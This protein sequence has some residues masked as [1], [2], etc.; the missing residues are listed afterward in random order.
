MKDARYLQC[1]DYF[2]LLWLLC[3]T[4]LSRVLTQTNR[5]GQNYLAFSWLWCL[6]RVVILSPLPT[7]PSGVSS[8]SSIGAREPWRGNLGMF[9]SDQRWVDQSSSEE[10]SINY[11]WTIDSKKDTYF[12]LKM[13]TLSS[14]YL[15]LALKFHSI[16]LRQLKSEKMGKIYRVSLLKKTL[17]SFNL[18]AKFFGVFFV[19]HPVHLKSMSQVY[20]FE[21]QCVS[22][23]GWPLQQC[24][25]VLGRELCQCWWSSELMGAGWEEREGSGVNIMMMLILLIINTLRIN[26]K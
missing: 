16:L 11:T 5:N 1:N 23:Y 17:Q 14:L 19:G 3:C 15:L 12:I 9:G 25:S 21:C 22:V 7:V 13:W 26:C 18:W 24:E 10:P 6:V 4:S 2:S 20:I 8:D